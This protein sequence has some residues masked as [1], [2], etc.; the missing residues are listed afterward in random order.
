ML[1]REFDPE[2]F[3]IGN[4]GNKDDERLG[5]T[6]AFGVVNALHGLLGKRAAHDTIERIGRKDADSPYFEIIH[7]GHS[8]PVHS[9]LV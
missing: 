8:A 3:D 2:F 4:G 1:R 5:L 9:A 7:N 6:P